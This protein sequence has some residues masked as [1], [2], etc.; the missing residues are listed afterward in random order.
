[1]WKY[2]FI[3]LFYLITLEVWKCGSVGFLPFESTM[4]SYWQFTVLFSFFVT[5]YSASTDDLK[6]CIQKSDGYS[7]YAWKDLFLPPSSPNPCHKPVDSSAPHE[8][9][10]S[11]FFPDIL[12]WDPLS[13]IPSLK[14]FLKCSR[15]ACSGKTA[16]L[17]SS[18]GKIK[19]E[20]PIGIILVDCM[21]WHVLLC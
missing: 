21:A 17:G 18:G 14:G 4:R 15:E 16:S 11:Y 3:V 6:E 8:I 19:M 1:M 7:W 20:R 10:Y 2:V 9:S 5:T 12:F 13:R